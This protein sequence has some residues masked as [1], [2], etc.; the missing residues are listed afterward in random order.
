M[1]QGVQDLTAFFFHPSRFKRELRRTHAL[2]SGCE[3]Q[4]NRKFSCP[5]TAGDHLHPSSLQAVSLFILLSAVARKG[6]H[7]LQTGLN[8]RYLEELMSVC[9]CC[10][11]LL[12]CEAL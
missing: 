8:I 2:C 12:F 3:P 6:E 10:I 11:D 1:E 4:E 9:C 5:L 7:C